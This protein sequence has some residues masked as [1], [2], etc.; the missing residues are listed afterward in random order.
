M[1]RKPRSKPSHDS[2]RQPQHRGR[3]CPPPFYRTV[4]LPAPA[5]DSGE[6]L[7]ASE[8]VITLIRSLMADLLKGRPDALPLFLRSSD[9]LVRA[10]AAEYRRA[11]KSDKELGARIARVMNDLGEQFG[12]PPGILPPDNGPS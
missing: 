8:E 4:P 6:T 3:R 5:E 9:S 2:R 11:H 12:Q 7:A 1:T 10:I